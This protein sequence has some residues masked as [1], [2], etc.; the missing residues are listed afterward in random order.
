M[1]VYSYDVRE[2]RPDRLAL[3]L[4]RTTSRNRMVPLYTIDHNPRKP[5]M[6]AI[7]GGSPRVHVYD[8]RMLQLAQSDS[9]VPPT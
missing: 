4:Q 5:Y 6:F 3:R 9:I 1:Q 8:S 2:P 7:A